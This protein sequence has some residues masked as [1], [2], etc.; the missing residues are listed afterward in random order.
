[1]IYGLD[2][3]PGAGK[4]LY[5]VQKVIADRMK[6]RDIAGN[7]TPVHIFHNIE[8]F[9]NDVLACLSG[10]SPTI[11][12][13][14]VH[15][16]T[17]AENFCGDV[18]T[19]AKKSVQFFYARP[20]SVKPVYDL[21]GKIVDYTYEL[22]PVGSIFI[23]DEAQNFFSSRDFKE[24]YS[25]TLIPYLTRHRHYYHSVWW[26]SQKV[27][28]V[29]ITFRRNTEQVYYLENLASKALI[30]GADKC[31]ISV[32]ESY[33]GIDSGVPPLA[34]MSYMYDKRFYKCYKSHVC[35]IAGLKENRQINNIWRNSKGL[36]IVLVLALICFILIVV[37]FAG[38]SP[39]DKMQ[40]RVASAPAPAPATPQSALG[41]LESG[42]GGSSSLD[43]RSCYTKTYISDGVRYFVVNGKIKRFN[44]QIN[45]KEC[46]E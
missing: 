19:D 13:E 25:K 8:G 35:E 40:A 27:D 44:R 5:F 15:D 10:I 28:Q 14:F 34:K 45:Y 36:R 1:M 43:D 18:V 38:G 42:G 32:Y 2:G 11:V 39:L 23:I 30:G 24:A 37:N 7:L 26:A 29:D 12:N 6:V 16:L 46:V 33:L 22:R 9:N 31:Q 41:T 4:T 20:E 3:V 21:D 17:S